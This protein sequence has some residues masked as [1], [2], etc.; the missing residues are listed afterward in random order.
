MSLFDSASLCLIFGEALYLYFTVDIQH[1]YLFFSSV[2]LPASYVV[3][4]LSI[5]VITKCCS[6]T[7]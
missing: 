7:G 5:D 3:H 1:Q 2:S 4:Q 6:K